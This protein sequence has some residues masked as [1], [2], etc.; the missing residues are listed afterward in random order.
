MATVKQLDDITECPVC[1]EVYRDPRVL[2]CRHSFC[3]SCIEALRNLACP[4]CRTPFTLPNGA[5]DLPKNFE[6][7][8]LQIKKLSRVQSSCEACGG[9]EATEMKAATVYC[10]ECQQKLCQECKEH[11]KKFEVTRRHKTVELG[12]CSAV[13][14]VNNTFGQLQPN[15]AH[16]GF[17][18]LLPTALRT[19][20]STYVIGAVRV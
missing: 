2:P 18:N 17:I 3:R 12:E 7:N 16:T 5:D 20:L 13:N 15:T 19:A 8:F 10:V 9:V 4:L 1:K 14:S 6:V 11:H